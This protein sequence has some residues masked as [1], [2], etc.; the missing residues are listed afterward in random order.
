MRT[1]R[2]GR[3][4]LRLV[5]VAAAFGSLA[6]CDRGGDPAL[7]LGTLERDRVELVAEA[8][9]PL[10][11]IAVREGDVLK[12]G[13]L[14]A[15]LDDRR[16][17]IDLAG[18]EAEIARLEAVLAEQRAGA[19]A[20]ELDEARA[21]VAQADTVLKNAEQ[22]LRRVQTIRERGLVAAADVDRARN[23]RDA[24][25]SEA[26]AARARVALLESGTRPESI[27]Q[28]EAA[29]AAA[30]AR[31]D[32]MQLRIERL[33]LVAPRAARVESLPFEVGDQPPV[34]ATVA[35]LLVGDAP[36]ALLYVPE[37]VR[38]N[39]TEGAAFVIRVEGREQSYA[40]RLKSIATEAGFTPYYA[41]TG[42]DASRLV[43]RAEVELT[44]A[45]ARDLPAGVPVTAELRA[46]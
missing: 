6:A 41:L 15:Q 29:L 30:V 3:R 25:A 1:D 2:V 33:R 28:T 4:A 32:L 17:R 22:E 37:S 43:Y 20:E 34:G 42:D 11:E 21:R 46:P 44:D 45:A 13:D 14:V 27:R 9:E 19:R 5:L 16:L 12:A 23:Q 31:R 7:I 38:A 24:Q 8:S 39:V 36:F 10:L 40:G 18:A 35:R 26:K